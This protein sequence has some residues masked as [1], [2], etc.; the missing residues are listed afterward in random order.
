LSGGHRHNA[1]SASEATRA[2]PADTPAPL[3]TAILAATA[4]NLFP[5]KVLFRWRQQRQIPQQNHLIHDGTKPALIRFA[6]QQGLGEF[7]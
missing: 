3:A 4:G 1:I 6:T 5:A 7:Q 2:I